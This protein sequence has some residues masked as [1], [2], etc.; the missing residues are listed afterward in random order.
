MVCTCHVDDLE[1]AEHVK[2]AA[3]VT[4]GVKRK[5]DLA[6]AVLLSLGLEH[7]VDLDV[8]V[9][10]WFG[11]CGTLPDGTVHS[12]ECD[13][14][15]DG[16]VTIWRAVHA[17]R[18]ARSAVAIED[19]CVGSGTGSATVVMVL[20]S[21]NAIASLR[22]VEAIEEAHKSACVT[23]A[24]GGRMCSDRRRLREKSSSIKERIV[25]SWGA[26]DAR[27]APGFYGLCT[28]DVKHGT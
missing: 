21:A 20:E 27:D 6:C 28:E 1:R 9:D 15:L 7:G 2:L 17:A 8:A 5:Q 12:V 13:D 19:T 22:E 14:P 18:E 24:S 3:L 25:G 4:L 23:C 11:V 10:M 26:P 16:I